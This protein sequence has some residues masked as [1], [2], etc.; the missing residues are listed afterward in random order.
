MPI[1]YRYGSV[2]DAEHEV[3]TLVNTVNTKGVMGKGLA[4]EFKKRYPEMFRDYRVRCERGE[5]RVGE[6]YLYVSQRPWVLNFP[7]KKHWRNKSRLEWIAQGLKYFVC[8]YK[9]WG[10]TSIAFPQLGTLNGGLQWEEVRPI[11]E[12][13]L[14]NLDIPVIIYIYAP[15]GQ[16]GSQ[17]NGKPA[18]QERARVHSNAATTQGIL[19]LEYNAGRNTASTVGQ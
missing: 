16:K 7:T 9:Q 10:I 4:L 17:G 1:E 11:M 19:P 18:Q 8:N 13:F 3:Q 15:R 6:P 12:K 5:V 2:F 14:G